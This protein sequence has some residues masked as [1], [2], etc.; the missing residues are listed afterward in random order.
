MASPDAAMPPSPRADTSV[1]DDDDKKPC[2]VLTLNTRHVPEPVGDPLSTRVFAPPTA[3]KAL[4]PRKPV[5]PDT[6]PQDVPGDEEGLQVFDS[7]K[8]FQRRFRCAAGSIDFKKSRLGI[9]WNDGSGASRYAIERAVRADHGTSV[10][11]SIT[12]ECAPPARVSRASLVELPRVE[13]MV[14]IVMCP[15][16]NPACP[17]R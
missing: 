13:G 6:G 1:L 17:D 7:Q 12:P 4:A 2:F 11:V 10:V 15:R 9:V 14:D 16:T 3:C 8:D 5:P